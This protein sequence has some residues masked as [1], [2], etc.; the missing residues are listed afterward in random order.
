M[1]I[2]IWKMIHLPYLSPKMGRK[3]QESAAPAKAIA[4][5]NPIYSFGVQ[6]ISS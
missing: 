2:V 6:Y 5:I 4:P 1:P 3:K